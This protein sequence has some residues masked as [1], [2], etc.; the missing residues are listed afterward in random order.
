ASPLWFIG[1]QRTWRLQNPRW[2]QPSSSR[3]QAIRFRMIE[4]PVIAVV[5]IAKTNTK[6]LL[7]RPRLK[8][9]VGMRE[10]S[11]G[12]IQ[13]RRKVIAF[14]LPF[15]AYQLRLLVALMQMV[16]DRTQII[17]KLTVD[18]P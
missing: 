5:P 14:G 6:V 8:P 1:Q 18:R 10:I 15:S 3:L 2:H 17:E 9:K 12:C 16:R 11:R 4:N 13:L 7:R